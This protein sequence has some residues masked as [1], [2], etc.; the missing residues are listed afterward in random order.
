[1]AFLKQSEVI[2]DYS[3]VALLLHVRQEHSSP[4]R[5]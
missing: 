1:V 4:W 3:Q 2:A 5:T